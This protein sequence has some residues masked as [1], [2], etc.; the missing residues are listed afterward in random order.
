MIPKNPSQNKIPILD[1]H[2]CLH[3]PTSEKLPIHS[4]LFA[5]T[6]KNYLLFFAAEFWANISSC[7]FRG[8]LLTEVYSFL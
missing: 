8:I 1:V 6:N 2:F 4:P 5:E 7:I 3:F